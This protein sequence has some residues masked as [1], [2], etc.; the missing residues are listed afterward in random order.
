[1]YCMY[2]ERQCN[3][4]RRIVKLRYIKKQLFQNHDYTFLPGLYAK[5]VLSRHMCMLSLLKACIEENLY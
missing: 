1:M 3:I 2:L 4:F 5:S